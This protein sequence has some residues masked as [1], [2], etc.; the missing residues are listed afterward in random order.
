M[1]LITKRPRV[2][3]KKRSPRMKRRP[4]FLGNDGR[5]ALCRRLF[6]SLV[7]VLIA[8][9]LAH[10]I[11]YAIAIWEALHM[12]PTPPGAPAAPPDLVIIA[13]RVGSPEAIDFRMG[14]IDEAFPEK[15][16]TRDERIVERVSKP[17]RV[18][19]PIPKRPKATINRESEELRG[20]G[21]LNLK[22]RKKILARK[23]EQRRPATADPSA[24]QV[25]TQPGQDI[26]RPK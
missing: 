5:A 2:R 15:P 21:R 7:A 13:H 17:A 23:K 11:H 20:F 14:L 12:S 25:L 9:V 16:K 6:V 19:K 24:P 3:L 10:L 18:A 26:V 1:K 22:E 4:R 8:Y